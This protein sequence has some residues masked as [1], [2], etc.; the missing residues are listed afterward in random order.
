[1]PTA[2]ARVRTT[3]AR[4]GLPAL[5]PALLTV[6]ALATGCQRDEEAPDTPAAVAAPGAAGPGVVEPTAEHGD[7][8]AAAA[9]EP[10][11]IYFD[12]TV[13]DW[14]R[15][16]QPLVHAGHGYLPQGDP[17]PVPVDRLQRVDTYQGVNFYALEGDPEPPGTVYVPVFHGYW[18]PFV[19]Q[20]AGAAPGAAPRR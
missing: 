2:T 17:R 11:E 8:D 10:E 16:G 1:M 18:Q 7:G 3:P 14:Y 9:P 5:L 15:Q 13:F 4:T 19:A 12:L 6:L 20:A